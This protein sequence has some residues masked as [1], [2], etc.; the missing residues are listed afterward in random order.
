MNESFTAAK[1]PPLESKKVDNEKQPKLKS[2][3]LRRATL[4]GMLA[5]NTLSAFASNPDTPSEKE[6]DAEKIET[7]FTQ[8]KP[9][10]GK[11]EVQLTIE[12][13]KE[14]RLDTLQFVNY[15]E[16]DKAE[17]SPESVREIT[18]EFTSFLEQVS[19]S[20][21]DQ[22]L[23]NDFII[24]ASCD[25][26]ET[27][28]WAGGN[29]ELAQARADAIIPILEKTIDEF[30]FSSIN[31]EQAQ[32]IKDKLFTTKMPEG[33]ITPIT[34]MQSPDG[35]PYTADEVAQ[36]SA[37][38]KETL[39]AAARQVDFMLGMESENQKT[40][41]EFSLSGNYEGMESSGIQEI[42]ENYERIILA[43]DVSP[44][45]A[46]NYDR[47][48][49]GFDA[50]FKKTGVDFVAE[51]TF[52]VVPYTN[53]IHTEHNQVVK[54][55]KEMSSTFDNIVKIKGS[56]LENPQGVLANILE[57]NI[58]EK[59]SETE[60]N[61]LLSIIFDEGLPNVTQESVQNLI[62]LSDQSNIDVVIFMVKQDDGSVTSLTL[63]DV[64]EKVQDHAN[65][66]ETETAGIDIDVNETKVNEK[67]WNVSPDVI[68]ASNNDKKFG[69]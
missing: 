6:M 33:G 22:I 53:V 11:H 57:Q 30:N 39:Y 19:P 23:D 56:V 3:W 41:T 10:I 29:Q 49:D 61:K 27:T 44:S 45:M 60:S 43:V 5:L 42:F 25:E 66:N 67:G 38:E 2:R 36:M 59:K 13:F 28:A 47:M 14:S 55:Q 64:M 26:R 65:T 31:P 40:E 68:I 15:F 52:S 18:S 20:N 17:T 58:T 16:V 69:I 35:D 62:D 12:D 7:E 34:K 8:Q 54:S 37:S 63:N 51:K 9:S 24:F 50:S 48:M 1:K 21:V 4:T 32:Q 46:K